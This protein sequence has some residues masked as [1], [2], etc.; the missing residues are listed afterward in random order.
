MKLKALLLKIINI[1]LFYLTKNIYHLI[2][3]VRKNLLKNEILNFSTEK[4][5]LE[6]MKI[7]EIED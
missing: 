5:E 2:R 3:L 7:Y 6:I 1:L 4:I